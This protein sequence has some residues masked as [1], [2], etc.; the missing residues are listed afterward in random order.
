MRLMSLKS[1]KDGRALC[2]SCL[3][4]LPKTGEHYAPHTPLTPWYIPTV[5]HPGYTTLVIPTV[6]HPGLYTRV[7]PTIVHRGLYHPGTYPP[8][9]TPH[10]PPGYIPTVVHPMHTLGYTPCYTPLREAYMRLYPVIPS[11]RP[12]WWL[13]SV[14]CSSWALG[15][16]E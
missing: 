8:L 15:R 10:I 13:M 3:S 12:L 14:M 6:V 16:S 5:V 2:A 7:I 9:Y 1:P 4:F 11:G